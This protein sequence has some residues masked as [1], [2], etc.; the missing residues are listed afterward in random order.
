MNTDKHSDQTRSKASP[1]SFGDDG[2]LAPFGRVPRLEATA[3]RR[4]V[5]L[6]ASKLNDDV[7]DIPAK[8]RIFVGH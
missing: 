4:C 3:S 7:S 1:V 6:L 8:S 2:A 5:N